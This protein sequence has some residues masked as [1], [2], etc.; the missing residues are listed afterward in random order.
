M[1]TISLDLANDAITVI[2][3]TDGYKTRCDIDPKGAKELAKALIM[4]ATIL[5]RR[6]EREE[7]KKPILRLV[8]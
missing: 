6:L 7:E 4:A 1:A 5:R 3:E 2:I 8:D